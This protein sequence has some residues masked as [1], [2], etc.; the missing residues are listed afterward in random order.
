MRPRPSTTTSQWIE[1]LRNNPDYQNVILTDV[2]R[3]DTNGVYLFTNTAEL[4]D[5]ALSGRYV[6]PTNE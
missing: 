2:S 5:Q 3:D 6:E 4:T 1:T